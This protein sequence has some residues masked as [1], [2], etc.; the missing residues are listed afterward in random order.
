MI[1]IIDKTSYALTSG[2]YTGN[3]CTLL[4]KVIQLHFERK[5][6]L[7]FQ[8]KFVETQNEDDVRTAELLE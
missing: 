8:D 1:S 3:L 6:T 7:P 2:W 4:K 5:K